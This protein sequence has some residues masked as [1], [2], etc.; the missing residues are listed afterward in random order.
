MK[1]ESLMKHGCAQNYALG[2]TFS[3]GILF[4]SL[5]HIFVIYQY[6]THRE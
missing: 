2:L 4:I 5:I 3:G 1:A 6:L